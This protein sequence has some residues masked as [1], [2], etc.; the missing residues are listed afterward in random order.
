[1]KLSFPLAIYPQLDW[2]KGPFQFGA[3][4][5]GRKHAACDLVAP[6]NTEVYAITNGVVAEP[7]LDFYNGTYS[8]VINHYYCHVRYGEL[9]GNGVGLKIGDKV[10]AGQVIGHLGVLHDKSSMLHFELYQGNEVGP[11]TNRGN[12]PFMRRKDLLD[13]TQ[14]LWGLALVRANPQFTAEVPEPPAP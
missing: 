12:P 9:R 1:M 4:R 5:G 11:Y 3:V 14:L 13:P 10:T 7:L 6:K 2:T 8:I